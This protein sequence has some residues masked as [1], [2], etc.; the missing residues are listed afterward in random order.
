[1]PQRSSSA[2]L[3][4]NVAM[5]AG[6]SSRRPGLGGEEVARVRLE[7]QHARRHAAVARLVDQ[8]RQHRLVAAVHAVEVADRQRA[9]APGALR[10]GGS[11]RKTC[12]RGLWRRASSC[13]GAHRWR[14]ASASALAP[15]PPAARRAP[16]ALRCRASTRLPMAAT[17]RLTWWYLPSSSVSRRPIRPWLRRRPRAPVRGRRRAP[18]RLSSARQRIGDRDACSAHLVD[19]GHVVLGRRERWIS[20]PSSVSS[21]RP[22]VSS[23][24]RPIGCTPRS[25][26]GAGSRLSTLG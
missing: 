19:L 3:S 26:S 1:M 11:P 16:N 6:A 18:R 2:S 13:Q 14:R 24:S 7:G 8:Q 15:G 9:A 17:M 22:V 21:S 25:R 10:G 5:R 4:R 20:A 23:S 12:M